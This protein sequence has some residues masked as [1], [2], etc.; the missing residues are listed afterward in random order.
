MRLHGV[1]ILDGSM[2]AAFGAN[3]PMSWRGS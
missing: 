2:I 1:Q 3:Y